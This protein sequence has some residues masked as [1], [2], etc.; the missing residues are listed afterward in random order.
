MRKLFAIL[1]AT[2][3]SVASV[4]GLTF[5]VNGIF[6]GN[7]GGSNVYVTYGSLSYNSYSG[8]VTIPSTVTYNGKTYNVTDIGDNAFNGCINLTS[9]TLPNSIKKIGIHAFHGCTKLTFINIPDSVTTIGKAFT[10]C[11]KLNEIKIGKSVSY[12]HSEAFEGCSSLSYINWT[13]IDCKYEGTGNG[14]FYNLPITNVI[15][16]DSVKTIPD[17]FIYNQSKVT[18]ITLPDKLTSIGDSSFAYCSISDIT[19]PESLETIGNGAFQGCAN[20]T[21]IAI[22]N[23][24]TS[25]GKRVFSD[26]ASMTEVSLSL[27]IATIP[28]RAFS[29]CKSLEEIMKTINLQSIEKYAFSNCT[30]LKYAFIPDKVTDI[31]DGAFNACSNIS[32][33][34]IG[35]SVENMGKG[36][37]AYCS[38]LKTINYSAISCSGEGFTS[39]NWIYGCSQIEKLIIDDTV[40]VIPNNFISQSNP[41]IKKITIPTQVVSIGQNA[42]YGCSGIT[43]FNF[44]ADSC[45]A[46]YLSDCTVT[47]TE[48]TTVNIGN[49]VK[50]IPSY[51]IFGKSKVSTISIPEKVKSI[52][53]SAFKNCTGLTTLNYNADSCYQVQSTENIHWLQDSPN[54]ETVTIGENVKYIPPYFLV[55]QKNVKQITIPASV[56]NIS[57]YAFKN[58]TGLITINYNA[59][60]CSGKGFSPIYGNKT[61]YTNWL[62]NCSNLTKLN[63]GNTVRYIPAYFM[64]NSDI[65]DTVK[66]SSLE[67][68]GKAAFCNCTGLKYVDIANIRTIYDS[69][70]YGCTNLK[71]IKLSDSITYLGS[72]IFKNCQSLPIENNIRYADN[73]LVE[74][75][76]KSYAS[77]NIKE[78]VRYIGSSAFKNCSTLSSFDV[79]DNL[80][81]ICSEAFSGCTSLS[82]VNIPDSVIAIGNK[83]FSNCSKLRSIAIGEN[84]S[85]MGQQVLSGCDSIYIYMFPKEPPTTDIGLGYSEK[86]KSVV[87]LSDETDNYSYYWKNGWKSVYTYYP[88]KFLISSVGP[89][90][91]YAYVTGYW[92]KIG[93]LS[94]I[95]VYPANCVYPTKVTHYG[96]L[97]KESSASIYANDISFEGNYMKIDN[98]TPNTEYT[99]LPYAAFEG[100][101]IFGEAKTFKTLGNTTPQPTV[102][103]TTS[104]ATNIAQTTATL[105]GTA[106][107]TNGTISSKG[108]QYKKSSATAYSKVNVTGSTLTYNLTGLTANTDYSFRAFAVVS[109]DTT[110]G[111]VKTFKTLQPTVNITVTTLDATDITS[112]SARLNGK[113]TCSDNDYFQ[114]KGFYI[115]AKYSGE[116]YQQVGQLTSNFAANAGQELGINLTDL[117]SDATLYFQCYVVTTNNDTI[118]GT[119]KSFKTLANTNTDNIVVTTVKADHIANTSAIIYGKYTAD[120]YTNFKEFAIEIKKTNGGTYTKLGN[121]TS[122]FSAQ[123]GKDLNVLA[124]GLSKGTSYT[125][126][127]YVVTNTDT[128]FG[129]EKTFTTLNQTIK[130]TAT[131]MEPTDITETSVTLHGKFTANDYS[132]MKEFGIQAKYSG[133]KYETIAQLTEDFPY[134]DGEDLHTTLSDL[135][136]GAEMYVRAFVRTSNDTIFGTEKKFTLQGYAGIEDV[137]DTKTITVYPNPAKDVVILDLGDLV[138]D[139]TDA[140]TIINS[141]GQVVYKSNIQSQKS[142]IDVR[143]WQSGVYYIK[144]G[145]VTQKL[146]VK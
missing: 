141:I 12:L 146:I 145:D 109:G 25:I 17:K 133:G 124:D 99:L 14:W 123:A 110:F 102:T 129:G 70:F 108:F 63:I 49:N 95:I 112:T 93:E 83:A 85:S 6:Y 106:T 144:V 28:E 60:S 4:H 122:N 52:G 58:C 68:I 8:S 13:A 81:V 120:K 71:N 105:N 86:G 78:N 1:I 101:T 32:S 5:Y 90:Q 118:F 21:S 41:N 7:N 69:V 96:F 10:L 103:V 114:M 72:E 135:N 74:A 75:T 134:Y 39:T 113:Y 33:V 35:N 119:E 50:Y 57:E 115:R 126:R 40:K 98:L 53:I 31:G 66:S 38:K 62:D 37:F 100:D 51:F 23:S 107:V 44:N 20:L 47:W 42:F 55:N 67:F 73:F 79:P 48:L 61:I 91:S 89:E 130:I 27:N 132:T 2:V 30:S 88:S 26:C 94:S 43:E 142:E 111:E 87:V 84:V 45:N 22:P 24:V 139:N 127:V 116:T 36:V 76:D 131:T 77:Y 18:E 11:S 64:Y 56:V 137:K 121:L 140:I 59:D 16:G 9:V 82:C 104:A 15:I 138:L 125:Y 29:N 46:G 92:Q 117:N 65:V 19:L 128:I 34:T 97:L 136:K 143:G 80:R 3:V 54:L